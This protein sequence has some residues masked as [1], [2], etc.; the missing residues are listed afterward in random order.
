MLDDF[1][2]RR[3]YNAAA[4]FI[5]GN[6]ARGLGDKL[7]FVDP[8]RSLSYRSLQSR[9]FQF[10]TAL[11]TLGLRPEDRIAL[12]LYDTVD[13]IGELQEGGADV[14][15]GTHYYNPGQSW[16]T[17]DHALVSPTLL[18]SGSG[19]VW[20]AMSLAA[21]ATATQAPTPAPPA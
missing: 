10:A 19:L 18:D 2:K 12:L 13:S 8:E 15:L 1:L 20:D 9:S 7:A 5:D 4:D 14:Q 11:K 21:H 6:V 17:F 3:P 16:N